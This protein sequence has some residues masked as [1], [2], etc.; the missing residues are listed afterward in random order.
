MENSNEMQAYRFLQHWRENVSWHVQEAS[1]RGVNENKLKHHLQFEIM[2]NT[3]RTVYHMRS[4]QR[5]RELY[6]DKLGLFQPPTLSFFAAEKAKE[7][8]A[9]VAYVKSGQ[10]LI[11]P[12]YA[13]NFLGGWQSYRRMTDFYRTELSPIEELT[14]DEVTKM[15]VSWYR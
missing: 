7:Q 6:T 12:N 5:R 1:H 11:N 2:E 14:I 13:H 4:R 8:L 15:I 10:G 9:V 3:M